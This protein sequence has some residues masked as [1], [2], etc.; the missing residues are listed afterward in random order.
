MAYQKVK[1]A[2]VGCGQISNIYIRN[3]KELFSI[4]D[5]T[6][7]CNRS[8]FKAEEKSRLFHVDRILTFEEVL[9]DPEIELVVVL[10]GAYVHYEIIKKLLLAGK[11]VF[12]EKMFTTKIEEARE[13]VALAKEKNLL[14]GVAPDT[15]LGAG[16]QTARRVIDLGLVGQI[17]SGYVS[18]TRNRLLESE[19]ARFL[20][21]DGGGL[22]YDLGIYY[23]AA[24]VAL[25]GPVKSV[26][27][28]GAPAYRHEKQ[29]LFSDEIKES[30]VIPGNN[31]MAAA[32]EFE[33]GA[34]VSVHFDG[35]TVCG[36]QH[37]F[38]L[39]GTKG[40]LHLGDPNMFDTEVGLQMPESET[41]KFPFT[42]GYNGKNVTSPEAWFDLYGHRGVGV[43]EMAYAIRQGRENR[44]SMN[45]GLHC[46]EVLTG[47]DEAIA[48]GTTYNLV[49]RCEVRPLPDGFYSSYGSARS[50]A[51]RSLID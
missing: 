24:L 10:T 16:L 8:P 3:L 19:F 27:G 31:Q 22:P 51:E 42:H 28:F 1:T 9:E 21:G 14:I 37:R 17:T 7:L 35:N 11:H 32:L 36:E 43:A 40:I 25:L 4:I 5:V 38:E 50:D 46:E 13:L 41:V 20:Q 33:S 49:S 2:V 26:R 18:V 48:S 6:A 12:T 45:Y 30:W 47:L 39:F 29:L 44:L 34:L 15:V 23:I